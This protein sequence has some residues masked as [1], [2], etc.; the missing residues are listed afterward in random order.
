MTPAEEAAAT[1]KTLLGKRSYVKGRLTHYENLLA[2]IEEVTQPADLQVTLGKINQ[3]FE[4]FE[5]TQIQLEMIDQAKYYE[6]GINM[7]NKHLKLIQ[8]VQRA[9]DALKEA[10]NPRP[11]S[12]AASSV[13]S[14]SDGQINSINN[15]DSTPPLKKIAIPN[16]SGDFNDWLHFKNTFQCLVENQESLSDITKFCYLKNSLKGEALSLITHL[17]MSSDN[18]KISW[19]ILMEKYDNK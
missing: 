13:R 4:G 1:L 8:K 6:E 15:R 10:R 9:I 19:D 2:N 12:S 7:D 11:Q 5:P 16:F 18:Y 17:D 3:M 14:E